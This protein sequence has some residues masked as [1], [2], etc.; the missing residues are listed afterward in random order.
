M[1]LRVAEDGSHVNKRL[2]PVIQRRELRDS[3][4][5]SQD[6]NNARFISSPQALASVFAFTHWRNFGGYKATWGKYPFLVKIFLFG[7]YCT[8]FEGEQQLYEP[9]TDGFGNLIFGYSFHFF[10]T[11][12]FLEAH[13]HTGRR[14]W[15]HETGAL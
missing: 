13:N 5:L 7:K 3:R 15:V 8:N 9:L 11:P 14:L 6:L 2:F 10:Q 12:M 1:P 4:D